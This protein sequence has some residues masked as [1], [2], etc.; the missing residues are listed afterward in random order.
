MEFNEINKLPVQQ[1]YKVLCRCFTYNQAAYIEDALNGFAMQQ[2]SFPFVC[3]VMDDCSTDGEQE[4]IR[5]WMSENCDITKVEKIDIPTSVVIVVPHKMNHNCTFAFYFLKENLYK[6]REKKMSHLIAWHNCCTYEATCEGDDY[7]TDPHKLQYQ[8]DFLDSHPEYELCAHNFIEYYQEQGVFDKENYFIKHKKWTLPL[9][10]K[11]DYWDVSF[12][13]YYEGWYIQFLTCMTRISS[14]YS[15][16]QNVDKYKFPRDT[17]LYY[18]YLKEGK[19]AL[20]KKNMG[21]YRK[22]SNGIYSGAD[23]VTNE[24]FA[25][26]TFLEFLKF[27]NDRRK[28]DDIRKRFFYTY[29]YDETKSNRMKEMVWLYFTTMPTLRDKLMILRFISDKFRI[30]IGEIR[31]S[32]CNR[33]NI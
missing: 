18:Y 23:Y 16:R 5:S 21:V 24:Y 9:E 20:F 33:N 8:A 32:F 19:V 4:V 12:D 30:K 10:D 14:A 15:I 1:E 17:V 26:H 25:L 2:T 3:L 6:Q 31:R 28:V 22:N 29:I 11:G 27:E 7:W 13:N